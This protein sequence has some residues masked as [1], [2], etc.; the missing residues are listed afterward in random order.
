MPAIPA[1]EGSLKWE[2]HGPGQPGQKARPY[3]QYN[4]SKRGWKGLIPAV[5]MGTTKPETRS[6]YSDPVLTKPVL[7]N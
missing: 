4:Q 1:M 5:Q 2:D 3:F 7:S 6:I